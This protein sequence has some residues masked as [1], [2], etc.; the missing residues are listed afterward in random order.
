[1]CVTFVFTS[2]M[3][4]VFNFTIIFI[5]S[6]FMLELSSAN[7]TDFCIFKFFS[8][9]NGIIYFFSKLI[10]FIACFLKGLQN[11]SITIFTSVYIMLIFY[12]TKFRNSRTEYPQG[13]CSPTLDVDYFS[14]L[15]LHPSI[16]LIKDSRSA[17]I[18][19]VLIRC[20]IRILV[21]IKR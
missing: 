18:I 1:M 19:G 7:V 14:K 10:I 15:F 20:L 11:F 12:A 21:L 13:I 8:F 3:R 5:I 2:I 6:A 16:L 4:M 9:A 17:Y